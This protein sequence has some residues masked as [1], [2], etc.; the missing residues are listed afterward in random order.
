MYLYYINI[1]ENTYIYARQKQNKKN[2]ATEKEYVKSD[3]DT[4]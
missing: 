1:Y 3:R 2:T 4:G